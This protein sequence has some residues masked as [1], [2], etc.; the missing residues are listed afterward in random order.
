MAAI[1]FAPDA[2][3]GRD[4][5]KAERAWSER[6]LVAPFR[7]RA[8][9]KAWE[10]AALAFV[11]HA[12]DGWP[13]RYGVPNSAEVSAEGRAVLA[14]GCD[15]PLA[16]YLAAW[17]RWVDSDEWHGLR[18]ALRPLFPKA[19]SLAGSRALVRMMMLD[20]IRASS[21]GRRDT[22]KE[23]LKLAE[24]TA[25]VARDGTYRRDEDFIFVRHIMADPWVGVFSKY[26]DAITKAL[27]SVELAEWVSETIVGVGEVL[28]AW[29]SR[30]GDTAD[31]VKPE[32]WQ[33]FEEHLAEAD[34]HLGTAWTLRPDQPMAAAAMTDV[35]MGGEGAPNETARTWFDRAIA[36]ECDFTP[37]YAGLALSYL[38]RWGGSHER[39]LKFGEACIATGRFDTEAPLGF[40]EMLGKMNRDVTDLQELYREP[41]VA[42]LVIRLS[43]ALVNEPSRAAEKR[44]RQCYLAINAWLTGDHALAAKALAAA[45]PGAFSRSPLSK[46]GGAH[47]DEANFRGLIAALNSP[48]AAAFSRAERSYEHHELDAAANGYEEAL[49]SAEGLA[50]AHI[51]SRI[52][53]TGMEQKLGA[54]EWVKIPANREMRGWTVRAGQWSASPADLPMCS[55]TDGPARITYGAR[56]G[57]DFEM[58]GEVEIAGKPERECFPGLIF[59]DQYGDENW[60]WWQA[61]Y[62]YVNQ[63]PP[64]G[65]YLNRDG[66]SGVSA[67]ECELRPLNTFSIRVENGKLTWSVNDKLIHDQVPLARAI[68]EDARIGVGSWLQLPGITLTLRKLEVRRLQK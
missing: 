14:A 23:G 6:V 16:G 59:G 1:R 15:D 9:G 46:L 60:L 29:E 52:E 57:P 11:G 42:P 40:F 24:Y 3:T 44:M 68:Q 64:T 4:F 62:L 33:G 28:F 47:T 34:K 18:S 26:H 25:A 37:A 50:A 22:S 2:K 61:C 55:G 12:L 27:E 41:R 38:P 13:G 66:G 35:L 45:G 20:F 10:A 63:A 21:A 32:G 19:E 48:A 36:A 39:M 5:Q 58:K 49:K 53:I 7:E 67:V 43:E 65:S 51:Q 54:G 17:A 30:G 8:K 56:V 31:K